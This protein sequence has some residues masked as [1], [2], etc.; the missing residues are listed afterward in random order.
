MT[1]GAPGQEAD[2][3]GDWGGVGQRVGIGPGDIG[4]DAR[5]VGGG[6]VGRGPMGRDA[7]VGARR[8][9]RVTRAANQIEVPRG[10][11]AAEQDRFAARSSS[12]PASLPGAH[13]TPDSHH[14][15]GRNLSTATW[16]SL[17][18][19]A[20]T[21]DRV[22]A[23]A[24]MDQV[25][26]R[27]YRLLDD[28]LQAGDSGSDSSPMSWDLHR[29]RAMALHESL[30]SGDGGAWAVVDW[31]ATDDTRRT[32]ELVD[33]I[34]QFLGAGA[35]AVV[36]TPILNWIGEVLHGVVT[37]AAKDGLK[38]AILRL[39]RQQVEGRINDF[40][41]HAGGRPIMRIDPR[42][43]AGAGSVELLGP[44][45]RQVT[46]SWSATEEELAHTSDP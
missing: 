36:I 3:V 22:D 25:T 16:T 11:L 21:T 37:D 23:E 14:R 20:Q 9:S 40:E 44:D 29:E 39:R 6:G 34:V 13:H 43:M 38:Q 10:E 46:V 30:G 7:L 33:V 15:P 19:Q 31:G 8:P 45:G 32:H 27:V 2:H 26:F 5:S 41:I 42:T 1:R 4:R 24:E 12:T 35:G 17:P 18:L 28:R